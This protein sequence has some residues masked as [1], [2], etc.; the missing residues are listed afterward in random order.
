MKSSKILV[1]ILC[2]IGIVKETKCQWTKLSD[3]DYSPGL[4]HTKDTLI[5]CESSQSIFLSA[6]QGK[7]WNK[8]SDFTG[9]IAFSDS[10]IYVL[11][12][13]Y[14][15]Q[16]N[17]LYY[18]SLDELN[19]S[20]KICYGIGT[21]TGSAIHDFIVFN[22]I[23]IIGNN[24][25]EVF[26]STDEGSN[27]YSSSTGLVVGFTSFCNQS[28]GVYD[29]ATDGENI[30]LGSNCYGVYKST[31]NAETWFEVNEGLPTE[32][33]FRVSEISFS[34]SKIFIAGGDGLYYS[35]DDGL[36][37]NLID[38]LNVGSWSAPWLDAKDTIIALST[39]YTEVRYSLNNGG[40]WY[41][42]D[43]DRLE[44]GV[45]NPPI[46]LDNNKNL[47]ISGINQG[48]I[49][50]ELQYDSIY[51][52]SYGLNKSNT[53]K[54]LKTDNNIYAATKSGGIYYSW[55]N[56]TNWN[57]VSNELVGK[58]IK[59]LVVYND[60]LYAGTNDG[61]YI[62]LDSAINWQMVAPI[63]NIHSL[64]TKNDFIVIGT[65]DKIYKFDI[66]TSVIDTIYDQSNQYLINTLCIIN[67]NLLV[68]T[69]D[70]LVYSDLNQISWNEVNITSDLNVNTLTNYNDSIVIGTNNSVY[71]ID[72]E[73]SS[74]SEINN[75]LPST[76][77]NN[78][79][80]NDTILIAATNNGIYDY[81]NG[82]WFFD[83]IDYKSF[84]IIVSDS[85]IYAGT[86]NGIYMRPRN[87]IPNRI[88]EIKLDK[89]Y[90]VYPNPFKDRINIKLNNF[91]PENLNIFIYNTL[92]TCVFDKR[93][94]QATNSIEIELNT[95]SNGIYFM[96]IETEN[97]NYYGKIIIKE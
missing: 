12:Y 3:L 47:Y 37:W 18:S 75:G 95:L 91:R 34:S 39:S 65:R 7:I 94:Y 1:L 35:V 45:V 17:I 60:L 4:I 88:N 85:T 69:A 30:Y 23:L 10:K 87:F 72:I 70:G 61:L 36:N 55:N 97:S 46:A 44:I 67:N 83:F 26:K 50:N 92:G 41:L 48:I 81:Y 9:I 15:L 73:F 77:V 13:S 32:T 29:L 89:S 6:N 42:I 40:N 58:Y 68:G 2:L 90:E 27:W 33:P 28:N 38:N 31:D 21:G 59:D 11:D 56:G 82:S 20:S 66:T 24:H 84:D 19:W 51:K 57:I 74:I 79:S 16:S 93:I 76:K 43:D 8:V 25:G 49:K 62:S 5:F 71:K 86:Y 54:L 52:V 14:D 96:Q 64:V 63:E 22:D 78:L 80:V 53:I